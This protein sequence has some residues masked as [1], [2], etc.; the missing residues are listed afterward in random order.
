M[1]MFLAYFC[2]VQHSL[3]VAFLAPKLY[4]K[5][6]EVSEHANM[7]LYH[8]LSFLQFAVLKLTLHEVSVKS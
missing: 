2:S 3:I 1:S 5:H 6:S 7:Y 8:M 4:L